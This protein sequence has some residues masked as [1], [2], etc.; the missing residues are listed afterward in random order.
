MWTIA[1]RAA[2][3]AALALM[4]LGGNARAGFQAFKAIGSGTDGPLA[5]TAQFTTGDG[6]INITL[7]NDLAADVIRSAS[8]ALSDIIITIS[9]DAGV[10]GQ[11]SAV[12]QLGDVSSTGSVTYVDG[13]PVR[14]LGVG[15]GLFTVE[16][17]L[18]VMETIGGGQP[19]Q[20]IAPFVAD[21]GVLSNVNNGFGNFNPYVIGPATFTLALSGVSA[22]TEGTDVFFSFGTQAETI[23]PGEGITDVPEPTSLAMLGMGVASFG[24]CWLRRRR[25]VAAA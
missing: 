20:M 5:A 6:V 14:W 3:A 1:P 11:T 18:I 25:A 12:G 4:A 16:G 19:D 17:N 10:L 7:S 2:L 13:S 24:A 8:Q 23:I 22:A 15:G 21:G 9:N